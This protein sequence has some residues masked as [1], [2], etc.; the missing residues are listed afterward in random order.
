MMP[1]KPIFEATINIIKIYNFQNGILIEIPLELQAVEMLWA[2][3]HR[4]QWRLSSEDAKY[5]CVGGAGG[6]VFPGLY[7]YPV[8]LSSQ[9]IAA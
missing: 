1:V 9:I 3:L 2:G 4:A 6:L 8:V 5:G 7:S